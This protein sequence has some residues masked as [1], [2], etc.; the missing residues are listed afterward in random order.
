MVQQVPL[1]GLAL[2][3]PGPLMAAAQGT[4]TLLTTQQVRAP[5]ESS[6]PETCANSHQHAQ[7]MNKENNEFTYT[8]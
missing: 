6:G 2:G 5:S 1:E 8:T 4:I 7:Q 3:V